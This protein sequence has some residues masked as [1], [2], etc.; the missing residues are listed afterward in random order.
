MLFSS[1][2]LSSKEGWHLLR[3]WEKL[4]PRVD[5][6]GPG[7]T[8]WYVLQ[9]RSSSYRPYDAWLVEH[10]QPVYVKRLHDPSHFAWGPY[11]LDVPLISIY[12]FKDLKRAGAATEQQNSP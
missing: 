2:D 10:A 8:E 4:K 6:T 1:Y 5:P 7:T 3:H 11:R 9:H 12:D